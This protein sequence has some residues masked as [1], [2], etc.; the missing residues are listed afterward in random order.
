[1]TFTRWIFLCTLG[2][3]GAHK[4]RESWRDVKTATGWVEIIK[5]QPLKNDSCLT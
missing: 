5:G 1:M 3:D 2:G 4:G